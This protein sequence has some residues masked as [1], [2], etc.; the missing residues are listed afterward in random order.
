MPGAT[1][2]WPG[3]GK[4][5]VR[6]EPH[7]VVHAPLF[8]IAQNVIGFLNVLKTILRGFVARVQ[9]RVKLAGEFP[10]SLPNIVFGCPAGYAQGFIIIVFWTCRHG[11]WKS[12]RNP[13][14]EGPARSV[15]LISYRL[16]LQTRRRPHL[17]S[18]FRLWK[19]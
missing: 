10:V 7:L 5:A 13:L 4:T 16:H 17:P 15:L 1:R 12:G 18:V 11:G 9:I 3:R 14:W 2:A 8:A 19:T 6:V